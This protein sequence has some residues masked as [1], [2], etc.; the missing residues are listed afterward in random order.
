M[1]LEC[2]K[3]KNKPNI[4]INVLNYCNECFLN[5]IKVKCNKI[6][7]GIPHNTPILVYNNA[8][9]AGMVLWDILSQFFATRK[10]YTIITCST[11]EFKPYQD[12]SFAQKDILLGDL[13]DSGCDS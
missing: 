11:M 13:E 12:F 4:Q 1:A 7:N 10:Y 9:P 6:L 3:C 5:N 2:V 8:C